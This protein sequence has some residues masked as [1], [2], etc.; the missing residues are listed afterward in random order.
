VE[1][2][3]GVKASRIERLAHDCAEQSPAVAI[4]GG[5]AL[6]HTNALFTALAVNALNELLGAVGQPGG[7]HF[8]PQIPMA[9][10]STGPKQT[11]DKFAAAVG[12]GSQPLG[13]LFVDD[14]N[15]V[16]ASPKAW[17]VKEALEKAQ[18][19]VSFASFVD[20]TSVLADLILP[21]HSFLESWSDA[22]PE[23]GSMVAVASVAAPPMKPLFQ[24]RATPDVLLDVAK[25]L[26]KPLGLTWD[27]Y[28][29]MLKATFDALGADAWSTAQK[30]G[31]WWGNLGAQGAQG[32]RGAQVAAVATGAANRSNPS[33]N[34]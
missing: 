20:E 24:T 32:A 29:A 13:L 5:V 9:G 31:G 11:L 7:L 30:Q 12:S 3:T 21:D 27:T 28:D 25:R 10:P 15:P 33:A 18:Y 4:A 6:A 34:P 2:I 19:I 22:L 8:T 26:K 14:A 17:K 1:Q 23:S 16:F